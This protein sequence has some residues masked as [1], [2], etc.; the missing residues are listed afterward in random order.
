M[1]FYS[2]FKGLTSKQ[3]SHTYS[4]VLK[5]YATNTLLPWTSYRLTHDIRVEDGTH[6]TSMLSSLT[7]KNFY[8]SWSSTQWFVS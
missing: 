2:G 5:N 7:L 6:Q 3:F 8:N 4:E 1:G